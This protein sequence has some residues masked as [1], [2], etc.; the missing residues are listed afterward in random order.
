MDG[1]RDRPP[2]PDSEYAELANTIM[3]RQAAL[4]RRVAAVFLVIVFGLP[5]ANFLWPEQA[6]RPAFGFTA[7]WLFLG[8]LFYPI[9]WLL[10]WYF[11]RE[12]DQIEAESVHW[13]HL[14]PEKEDGASPSS[15]EGGA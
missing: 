1:H 4:S 7:T 12:S 3:H 14:L 5:L 2:H 6:N 13:K 10:S 11:I 8:V 9:T 15:S